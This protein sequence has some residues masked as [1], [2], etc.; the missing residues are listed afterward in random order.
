MILSPRSLSYATKCVESLFAN[1]AENLEVCFMTD[2]AADKDALADVIG[3]LPNPKAHSW[4]IVDDSEAEVRANEQW[5][6]LP[7]LRTFR[8]GHPCWRKVT[9]PLLFSYQSEEMVIL[10]P[11]LYFRIDSP[12]SK[13]QRP[14]FG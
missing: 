6:S 9:D 7:N 13:L 8:R 5:A 4:H 11:D 10:D 12:S 14:V 3:P 2:S 1:A